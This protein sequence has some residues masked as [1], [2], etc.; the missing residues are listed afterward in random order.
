MKQKLFYLLPILVLTGCGQ[1]SYKNTSLSPE[2]RADLLVK[3][4][5]LEE[6]VQLMM[7]GSRPVER[8][9]IKPYNWWNEALHGVAR[10]GLATVFPQPIGMA[11]S[12]APKR[13]MMY[14]L[15]CLMR[16]VPRILII[17]LKTAVSVIRD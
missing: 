9:D 3:E 2:E 5:T 11:A 4:L 1:V 7:D 13:Y 17:H 16:R 14:S 10:A 12:L 15:P 6:K 8:L